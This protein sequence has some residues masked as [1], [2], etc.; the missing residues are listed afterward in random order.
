MPL[1]LSSRPSPRP[2]KVV[3]LKASEQRLEELGSDFFLEPFSVGEGVYGA[4]GTAGN[5][6]LSPSGN[7]PGNFGTTSFLPVQAPFGI[8]QGP[9]TAGLRSSFDLTRNQTVDDLINI[10]D[11]GLTSTTGTRS[12][13]FASVAGVF[14]NP[15]FQALIRGLNQKKGI[16]LS[17]AN[18]VVVKSG[19][20]ATSFSGRD[21]F[22]PTEFDPPQ[23]PQTVVA[24]ILI[25]QDTT[26]GQLFQVPLPLQQ[27]PVTPATPNSFEK[28]EIGSTIEVEATIGEDGY[29][30]ELNLAVSFS[31]FDG[32]I[33]YGTPIFGDSNGILLTEN[34]IIQPVFSRVAATTLVQVYDGQTV[35]IGGLSSAKVETIEDKV[36]GWSSIPLIG[37]FFKSNVNRT[38]RTAV[39]YFVT[40]NIVDP[41]GDRVRGGE[42]LNADASASEAA[43]PVLSDPILESGVPLDPGK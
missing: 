26:T 42:T 8:V 40:V 34:R 7:T 38:T 11:N 20:R 17:V 24:P 39:V 25:V 41:A 30:V 36:P 37:R 29:T 18:S 10:S 21:F 12:P 33:N 19:Q 14:T 43:A 31:E 32:F 6:E 27:P 22:Y 9:V 28:K 2:R 35:A 3:L 16:D 15:R 1:L 4:G 5:S 13:A 23:I